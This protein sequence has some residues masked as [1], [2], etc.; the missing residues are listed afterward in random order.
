MLSRSWIR[1]PCCPLACCRTGF[2]PGVVVVVTTVV[3]AGVVCAAVVVVAVVAAGVVCASAAAGNALAEIN[4]ASVTADA[5]V[6]RSRDETRP[7]RRALCGSG[8][9]VTATDSRA[10]FS[11]QVNA[12]TM[13]F[14]A[15]GTRN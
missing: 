1:N 7:E 12:P 13:R 11:R 8:D 14:T 3:V 15:T 10:L 4:H 2:V 5:R 9:S 6:T